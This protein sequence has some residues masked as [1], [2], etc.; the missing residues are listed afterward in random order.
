MNSPLSPVKNKIDKQ[1]INFN[2][3]NIT[4]KS[5]R[6]IKNNNDINVIKII[7][8]KRNLVKLKYFY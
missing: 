1:R 2:L 4:Y 5:K 8:I 3:E 6:Y 7:K